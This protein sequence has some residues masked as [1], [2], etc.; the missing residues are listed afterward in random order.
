MPLSKLKS[1]PTSLPEGTPVTGWE[2]ART[3]RPMKRDI[4][5]AP[6][7]K[8]DDEAPLDYPD[9]GTAAHG[10]ATSRKI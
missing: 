3:R 6:A 1:N 4:S 9:N 8:K 5:G 7:T 2:P 10:A